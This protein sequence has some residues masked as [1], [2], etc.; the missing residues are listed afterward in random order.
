M[1]SELETRM[2]KFLEF[3]ELFYLRYKV[4]WFEWRQQQSVQ[5]LFYHDTHFKEIDQAILQ[6]PNPF[7]IPEAFPYGETPLLVFKAI[8]DAC[9]LTAEDT[10]FELG[11]GRGRGAFFLNHYTGCKVVGIERI[12][13]F[14][15][16]AQEIAQRTKVQRVSFICSNMLS[17]DLTGATCIYL[18]GTC[19]DE[20]SIEIL[21]GKVLALP[22]STR[23]ISISFAL[24][25]SALRTSKQ[26]S[27]RFP[28]GRG[29]CFLQTI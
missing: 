25:G 26:I 15:S 8:A 29:T 22:S 6:T 12:P 1:D 10:V 23:I 17:A 18:Y 14:V 11:C 24:L 7:S 16:Q 27:L 5:S 9:K 28:W 21:R 3:F 20:A 2:H 4:K 19:L 13:Q